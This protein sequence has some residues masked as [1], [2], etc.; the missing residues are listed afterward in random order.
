MSGKHY[1]LNFSNGIFC[2]YFINKYK[3]AEKRFELTKA[4][5]GNI[6]W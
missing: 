6:S 2:A 1:K 3:Q 4:N 5:K